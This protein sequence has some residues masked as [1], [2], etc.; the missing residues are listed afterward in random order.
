MMYEEANACQ[1]GEWYVIDNA[2]G[3]SGPPLGK[4]LLLC[5]KAYKT[6][7]D[8]KGEKSVFLSAFVFRVNSP[9]EGTTKKVREIIF[10]NFDLFINIDPDP[11][12]LCEKDDYAILPWDLVEKTKPQGD[13]NDG[14][15]ICM[16]CGR[17]TEHRAFFP[18][19]SIDFCLFC[20][21]PTRKSP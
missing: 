5:G 17:D 15:T 20:E 8:A 16:W 11:R 18:G 9:K 3:Y 1:C 7:T 6:G 12:F 13:K 2:S 19:Y 4:E 21:P 10:G 14:R